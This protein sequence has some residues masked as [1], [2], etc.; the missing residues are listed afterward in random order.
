[1]TAFDTDD[2][3]VVVNVFVEVAVFSLH[4]SEVDDVGT[5][6]PIVSGV[7]KYPA[8]AYMLP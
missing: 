3:A 6:L 1:M 8:G 5:I 7:C 4:D 2:G